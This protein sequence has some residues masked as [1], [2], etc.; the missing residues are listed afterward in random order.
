MQHWIYVNV[1]N[2]LKNRTMVDKY[3]RR[4]RTPNLE[5]LVLAFLRSQSLW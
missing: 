1:T 3:L 4:F 2:G 5:S